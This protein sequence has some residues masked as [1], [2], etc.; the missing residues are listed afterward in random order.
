MT[1][2]LGGQHEISDT[3]VVICPAGEAAR[4]TLAGVDRKG[5]KIRSR[6]RAVLH[7]PALSHDGA[8]WP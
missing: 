1:T 6:R 3:H 4:F 2:P 5:A 7:V 8:R